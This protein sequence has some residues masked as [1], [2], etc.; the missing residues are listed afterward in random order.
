MRKVLSVI[1]LVTLILSLAACGT[2]TTTTAAPAATS[3]AAETTAAPAE[4]PAVEKIV[5]AN[6]KVEI[7]EQL[8]AF[9][10]EYSKT[11]GVTVEIATTGGGADYGGN[12]KAQL[13]SG[14]MP[15]IF[16]IEGPAGYSDWK[17]IIADLGDQPWVADTDFAY[18]VDGKIIGFPVAIEGYGMAYNKALL[19]KAGIDPK[20]L[21]NF[22]AYKAAFEKLEGMKADLGIDAVVSMAA[23]TATG[24]TWVTGL[25]N[26][27]I[28]L[29][30]G[31]PYG[32][33]TVIDKL[34][35]GEVDEPRLK[36]YAEY[37][38]MLF[39]YADKEVLLNGN[40]DAQAQAFAAGKTVF[41]HQG[42][43]VDPTLKT[44]EASFE[45][46]YAPHA[47]FVED[48]D[49]VLA[50][51]PSWYVVNGDS[52]GAE[53]AKKFL[54]AIATTEAGHKYMVEA[55]GM[56]PAFKSVK[57]T[58]AVPLSKSIMEWASA[59]KTYSWQMF[60]M[61]SG[62]GMDTLGP[63]Y[64]QLASG[65]VDTAGFVELIKGEVATVPDLLG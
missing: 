46:A 30:A 19:D 33:T 25:H 28:Y 8:K 31:L 56:I 37:V 21:T 35:A 13:Q 42:N 10:A 22:N 55:A 6:N 24:M 36:Q 9:A 41:L 34:L 63:I 26:F 40:Y 47:P 53:E 23:S 15:D 39:Q 54:N 4:K 62:F 32:D 5:L 17:D 18:T 50:A 60:K 44:L 51:P 1:L 45:M 58:P 59:G 57:L 3:A 2:T 16:V 7:D 12:L 64:E 20:T 61:P 27:N 49:G 38:N 29:T 52:A 43:W 11:A 65:A 14:N 48:T